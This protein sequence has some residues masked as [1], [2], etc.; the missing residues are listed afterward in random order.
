MSDNGTA[1][2][3]RFVAEG[4]GLYRRASATLV[5]FGEELERRLQLILSSRPKDKW[6][7]FAPSTT[8]PTRST[9]Y[10]SKY[11]LLNAKIDGTIGEEELTVSIAIN[12][13][14]AEGDYPFY[15]L[16][17]EPA[18]QHAKSMA[19]FEWC[20]KVVYDGAGLRLDPDQKDFDLERDFA[21]LLNEATRF[22]GENLQRKHD[23]ED[24]P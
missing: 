4:M 12:W 13:Y 10:W 18:D 19:E 6:G 1:A 7:A 16:S 23:R 8:R 2:I 21:L 22:L 14:E 3:D 15:S 24:R 11:P 9:R 17:F 20:G 5:A